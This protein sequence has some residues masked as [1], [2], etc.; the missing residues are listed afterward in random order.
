MNIR[1][2]FDGD[3][4]QFGGR[5]DRAFIPKPLED[6]LHYLFDNQIKKLRSL[7]PGGVCLYGEGYGPGIQNGGCYGK[8]Q[9]FVLFDIQV[10]CWWL[11]DKEVSDIALKLGLVRTPIVGLGTLPEM[12]NITCAGFRS[13]WGDFLAEGIVARPLVELRN[14]SGERIITKLKTSDKP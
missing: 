8:S 9:D 2:M 1:V 5:T 4:L 3:K 7:F 12:I 13:H 14:R 11:E 10:D 6:R